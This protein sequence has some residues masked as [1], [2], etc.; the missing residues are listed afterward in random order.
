MKALVKANILGLMQRYSI[1]I[2]K[3]KISI[4]E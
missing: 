2:T 1:K 3:I 4:I